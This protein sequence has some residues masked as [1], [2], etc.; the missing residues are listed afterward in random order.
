MTTPDLDYFIRRSGYRSI[1]NYIEL[2]D[3]IE[4]QLAP[5]RIH[6]RHFDRAIMV[7]GDVCV[8]FCDAVGLD[9]RQM[10]PPGQEANQ[11]IRN[12]VLHQ[13]KDAFMQGG[14][15]GGAA[16][17]RGINT[18]ISAGEDMSGGYAILSETERADL[19]LEYAPVNTAIHD[20]YGVNLLQD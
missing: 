15:V 1:L 12:D 14:E 13:W 4:T 5:A 17:L 19:M 7:G 8:D 11:S 6:V 10:R 20:R 18:A 9:F 2:L 16:F 3:R